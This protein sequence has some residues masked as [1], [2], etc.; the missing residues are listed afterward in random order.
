MKKY[1]NDGETYNFPKQNATKPHYKKTLRLVKSTTTKDLYPITYDNKVWYEKD[2]DDVFACFYS[3][4]EALHPNYSVYVSEGM[5]IFPD[6]R[7]LHTR[8]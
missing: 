6:G 8:D 7:T 1:D 2:V 5:Y 4:K 3:C